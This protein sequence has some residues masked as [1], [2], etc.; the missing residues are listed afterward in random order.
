MLLRLSCLA[1]SIFD[2]SRHEQAEEQLS[3]ALEL[4][5]QF[6]EAR[7]L[8]VGTFVYR[9]NWNMALSMTETLLDEDP[10]NCD[11]LD[12]KAYSLLQLCEFDAAASAYEFLLAASTRLR[13]TG[14]PMVM[15]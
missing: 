6:A 15:R 11:Y 3:K 12:T 7:W 8:L 13:K 10:D 5:P 9:G 1:T 14:C 4:A 2:L